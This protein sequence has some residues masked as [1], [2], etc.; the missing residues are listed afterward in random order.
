MLHHIGTQPISTDRLSLR[1]FT[2]DDS[3]TAFEKWTSSMDS[4]FWEPPHNSIQE[5]EAMIAEYVENYENT[6]WY[7]WAV[8]FKDKLIGLVCGNEI[9]EDI[10]SICIGYCITKSCWNTGIATEASKAIINY[11]FD[12]GFNRVFSYHNPLNPSSGRVMQKCG[13]TYEGRIRGGSMF[14][15][16]LCDCF[17][18]SILRSDVQ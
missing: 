3:A 16:E 10:K 1:R 7:M 13:M 4:K 5:T 9:N 18:Y 12:I 11:F 2:I 6:D 8:V 17:Q 14:A 15:G